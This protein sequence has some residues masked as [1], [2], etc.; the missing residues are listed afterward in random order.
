MVNIVFTFFD[1]DGG[2]WTGT[3]GG[4]ARGLR[5]AVGL[6]WVGSGGGFGIDLSFSDGVDR[7]LNV[8]RSVVKL[9]GDAALSPA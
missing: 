4:G 8:V 6:G 3:G 2:G 9:V 1:G 7:G 5:G